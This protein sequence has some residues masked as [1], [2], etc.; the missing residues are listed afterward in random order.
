[1]TKI[2]LQRGIVAYTFTLKHD[3]TDIPSG[4]IKHGLENPDFSSIISPLYTTHTLKSLKPLFLGYVFWISPYFPM[5]VS[6][7]FMEI[8]GI[9]RCFF[10][11]GDVDTLWNALDNGRGGFITVAWRFTDQ[12]SSDQQKVTRMEKSMAPFS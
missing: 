1:M 4:V 2:Y 11:P 6:R 10:P 8:R 3:P 9:S 5:L 12:I 7:S